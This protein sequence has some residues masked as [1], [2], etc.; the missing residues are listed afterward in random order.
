MAVL[1]LAI[2]FRLERYFYSIVKPDNIILDIGCG[3]GEALYTERNSR[4]FGIDINL[5]PLQDTKR[6]Y[7]LALQADGTH[8]PFADNCFDV[9]LAANVWEHFTPDNQ[10]RLSKEIFRV[11]R[12]GGKL[13]IVSPIR[14]DSPIIRIS[15]SFPQ[16]F[17]KWFIQDPKHFGLGTVD[18]Y[19]KTLLSTGF[20]L[21]DKT[22]FNHFFLWPIG[23]LKFLDQM[24][25]R[26]W[27]VLLLRCWERFAASIK[28]LKLFIEIFYGII[29]NCLSLLPLSRFALAYGLLFRKRD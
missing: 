5:Y 10:H 6:I 13:A 23:F 20:R 29:D 15:E 3:G 21:I 27:W 22:S 9:V 1:N 4:L 17:E 12:P 24:P 11:L 16:F 14:S 7:K 26:I 28:P 2:G 18:E 19:I 25:R 8:L